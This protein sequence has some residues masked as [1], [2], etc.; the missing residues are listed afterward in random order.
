MELEGQVAVVIGASRGCG[1]YF[2]LGLAKA[3]AAVT[4]AARTVEP[5]PLPGTV[6]E[7]AE[8]IRQ[9]GGKAFLITLAAR[10]DQR[11]LYHALPSSSP[12]PRS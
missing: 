1:K 12:G 3:G 8:Q 6:N 2:A 4:V 11:Q 7:T 9:E 5:G 10:D